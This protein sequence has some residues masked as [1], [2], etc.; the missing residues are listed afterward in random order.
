MFSGVA[1]FDLQAFG[2]TLTWCDPPSVVEVLGT[3]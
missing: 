3:T 2:G 1:G